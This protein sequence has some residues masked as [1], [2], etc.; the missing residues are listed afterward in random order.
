MVMRSGS[1]K[2]LTAAV[3]AAKPSAAAAGEISPVRTAA[4]TANGMSRERLERT[5]MLA[6]SFSLV[7]YSEGDHSA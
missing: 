6:M 2:P 3:A 7:H 5:Q 4:A 1:V